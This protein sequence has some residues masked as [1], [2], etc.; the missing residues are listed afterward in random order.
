MNSS[1]YDSV[2]LDIESENMKR[3]RPLL[4]LLKPIEQIKENPELDMPFFPHITLNKSM[5]SIHHDKT[6]QLTHTVTRK[7]G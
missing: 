7:W 3:T 2:V 4:S 5:T 6:D 1:W